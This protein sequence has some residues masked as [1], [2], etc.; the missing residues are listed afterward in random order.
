MWNFLEYEV[1]AK[2]ENVTME[3]LLHSFKNEVKLKSMQ[4]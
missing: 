2:Y 1:W 3:L 4:D